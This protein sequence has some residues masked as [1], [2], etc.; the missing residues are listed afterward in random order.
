MLF[1]SY[2]W[3]PKYKARVWDGKIRLVNSMTGQCYMGLA[4]RIKKFCDARGYGFTF[5]KEFAYKKI[6]P[7]HIHKFSKVIG[8]PEKFTPRDYQIAAVYKGVKSNRRTII[9]PTSSGKT[10]IMYMLTQWYFKEKALIIVP[11][12]GLVNQCRDDFES[13]GYK[14]VVHC[15][16]DGLSRD[17]DIP[18]DIVVTTWQSLENSKPRIP[19]QWYRQF[20]MVIGDEAHGAKATSMKKIME[21]LE[22]ARFRFGTTGTIP[23]DPLSQATIEGLFGPFFRAISTKEMQERG[24]ASDLNIICLV[25]KHPRDEVKAAK[26]KGTM[27]YNEEIDYLISS[28]KRNNYIKNL[29]MKLKGNKLLFFARKAHGKTLADLLEGEHLYYIDGGVKGETRDEIRKDLES[30][31]G[32]ILLASL[33]TTAT[34]VSINKLHH[35]IAAHPT[36]SKI[37][38]L[39]AIGRI[40]RLHEEKL[41]K[42]ATLYDIVDDMSTPSRDNY[43]LEHFRERV[44]YYD[45]EG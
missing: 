16:T 21:N 3:S 30:V 37:R 2:K 18:A 41:D 4:Q 45:A 28:E 33:G 20:G 17:N 6:T 22:H 24:F 36:K 19:K 35:M 44:K 15:S 14:G 31:D 32:A 26:T 10:L 13:F 1:R 11:T 27:K 8:L 9:S 5:D 42:G 12:I 29:T 25:L 38:V 39:Q 34:G 23:D 7:E 43:T 40:L